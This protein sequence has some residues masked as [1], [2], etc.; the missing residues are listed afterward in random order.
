MS[1]VVRSVSGCRSPFWLRRAALAGLL[2]VATAGGAIAAENVSVTIAAADP[3]ADLAGPIRSLLDTQHTV[4]TRGDSVIDFWWVRAVALSRG[5]EA[6]WSAVS[7]GTLVGA[8]RVTGPFTGIRGMV[9]KPGVYTLRF[10][11]QPQDGDHMGVSPYREFLLPCPAA[12]DT[13]PDPLGLKPTISLAKK[14][15]G[16]SHPS[17]LSID[18]P[19]STS[20]PGQVL[21]TEQGHTAITVALPAAAEGATAGALSFGL[22][23]VGTI[24][25]QM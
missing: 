2:I 3:P 6:S 11:R 16:E 9:L 21:T 5:G 12:A 22:I 8:L 19:A 23:V 4:V 20:P 1:Q 10:A 25:H 15:S 18:P 13:T 24:E 7:D 14:S 17:A